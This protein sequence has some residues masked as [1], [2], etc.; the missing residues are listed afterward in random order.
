MSDEGEANLKIN[1]E[2]LVGELDGLDGVINDEIYYLVYLRPKTQLEL[3]AD[4]S[5]SNSI[6]STRPSIGH[7]FNHQK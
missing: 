3:S 4:I 2:D 1:D 7:I 5:V 6:I